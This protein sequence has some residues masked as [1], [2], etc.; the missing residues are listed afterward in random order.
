MYNIYFFLPSKL[1][2]GQLK[3]KIFKSLANLYV[4]KK[5][6]QSMQFYDIFIFFKA[7]IIRKLFYLVYN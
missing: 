5:S 7:L 3:Y 1:L 6:C 2:K 4:L